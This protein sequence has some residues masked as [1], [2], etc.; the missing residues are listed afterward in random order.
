MD[1]G[2][3][4]QGTC[5]PLEEIYSF[6]YNRKLTE[7]FMQENNK[8]CIFNR[9]ESRMRKRRRPVYVTACLLISP[10]KN[11]LESR[12]PVLLSQMLGQGLASGPCLLDK[13]INI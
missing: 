11:H 6:K 4:I 3:V 2:G 9:F 8:I 5:G 7:D 12:T 13:W 10:N 1:E